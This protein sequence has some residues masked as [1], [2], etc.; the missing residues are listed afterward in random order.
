MPWKSDADS[1]VGQTTMARGRR[2]LLPP[3]SGPDKPQICCLS[4]SKAGRSH[5]RLTET[6]PSSSQCCCSSYCT[7]KHPACR[8]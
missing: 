1:C 3:R 6:G 8:W 2:H 5:P 4:P 7:C